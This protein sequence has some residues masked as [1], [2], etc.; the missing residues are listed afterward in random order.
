MVDT[1]LGALLAM[2]LYADLKRY[3]YEMWD[4]R[5]PFWIRPKV[6]LLNQKARVLGLLTLL[7]YVAEQPPRIE[8]GHTGRSLSDWIDEYSAY[9]DF[10]AIR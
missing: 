3:F 9:L 8:P 10:E 1:V 4:G 5:I 7:E 2:L 6:W